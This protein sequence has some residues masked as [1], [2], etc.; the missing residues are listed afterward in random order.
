MPTPGIPNVGNTGRIFVLSFHTQLLT[1]SYW[2][3]SARRFNPK[4]LFPGQYRVHEHSR[5]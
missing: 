1:P 2:V 5:R 4:P 3:F